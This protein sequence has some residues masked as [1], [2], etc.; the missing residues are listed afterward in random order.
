MYKRD[1]EVFTVCVSVSKKMNSVSDE[2]SGFTHHKNP[3]VQNF[4]VHRVE[5]CIKSFLFFETLFYV[6]QTTPLRR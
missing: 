5:I 3:I 4:V 6:F 2:M 1:L